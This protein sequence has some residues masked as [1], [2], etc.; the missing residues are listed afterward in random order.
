[1]SS[2]PLAWMGVAPVETPEFCSGDAQAS[3][4]SAIR[5]EVEERVFMCAIEK[6][7]AKV[8]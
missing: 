8:A 2:S 1:M 3:S 6:W 4:T 5:E 7:A